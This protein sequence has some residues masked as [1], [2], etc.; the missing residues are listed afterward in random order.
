[1]ESFNPHEKLIILNRTMASLGFHKRLDHYRPVEDPFPQRIEYTDVPGNTVLCDFHQDPTGTKTLRISFNGTSSRT[2][3]DF[4]SFVDEIST[5]L[6]SWMTGE[7][8]PRILG[9]SLAR[10]LKN[11]S[12]KAKDILNDLRAGMD[13]ALLMEKY[14]L[15]PR[16]IANLL[17]KLVSQGLLS[18][19]EIEVVK[20]KDPDVSLPVYKC[21]VC[22]ELQFA[23]LSRCPH[24]GGNMFSTST[25]DAGM[26]G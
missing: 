8:K 14:G 5:T 13:D 10:K 26:E 21:S 12:L 15:T 9:R 2:W 22:S 16:G 23:R 3:N 4:K 1:M 6:K 24:C 20:V 11:R 19:E 7:S 18:P 17:D 25:H